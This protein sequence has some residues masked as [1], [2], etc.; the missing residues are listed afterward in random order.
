MSL[1]PEKKLEDLQ[2]EL[3]EVHTCP[4]IRKAEEEIARRKGS[5][6]SRR[7]HFNGKSGI[8][9]HVKG[10][11]NRAIRWL[12]EQKDGWKD[13]PGLSNFNDPTNF[14][15]DQRNHPVSD[16]NKDRIAMLD[17]MA[18]EFNQIVASNADLVEPIARKA[19]IDELL[20]IVERV[21]LL[22]RTGS[23]VIE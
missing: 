4:V 8:S 21:F 11:W 23:I 6:D 19:K 17:K 20:L 16:Y 9:P 2:K 3:F 12:E 14:N 10:Q 13:F 7:P 1:F 22:I 5:F 18:K 15:E